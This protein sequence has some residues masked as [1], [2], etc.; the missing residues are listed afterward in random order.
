MDTAFERKSSLIRLGPCYV[1]PA[2]MVRQRIDELHRQAT[3]YDLQCCEIAAEG[4]RKQ[5]EELEKKLEDP[6]HS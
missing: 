4:C 3:Q 6:C 1:L 5:A 2:Y